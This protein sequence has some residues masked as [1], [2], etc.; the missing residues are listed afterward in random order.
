M[1]KWI[2]SNV[3]VPIVYKNLKYIPTFKVHYFKV[4]GQE[5]YL[6]YTIKRQSLMKNKRKITHFQQIIAQDIHYLKIQGR[7]H[8]KELLDEGK[9]KNQLGKLQR[10]L[11]MSDVKLLSTSPNLLTFIDCRILSHRVVP[12]LVSSSSQQ[13]SHSS[14]ISSILGYPRQPRLLLH[15]FI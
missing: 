13:V 4:E 10:L 6:R 9:T 3:K 14:G 8:I 12:L 1:Q 7:E 2:Q 11:S 15:S 5:S